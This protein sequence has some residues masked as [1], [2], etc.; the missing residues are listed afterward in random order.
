MTTLKVHFNEQSKAVS[1]FMSLLKAFAKRAGVKIVREEE[2]SPYDPAFE[3][4]VLKSHAEV[5]EG[6][7]KVVDPDNMWE[8]LGL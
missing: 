8:S 5:K 1:E 4:K 2:E 3:E 6:R 7:Y